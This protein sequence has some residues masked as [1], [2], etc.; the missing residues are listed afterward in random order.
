VSV[1]ESESTQ[2]HRDWPAAFSQIC[3]A[4]R[5][6]LV[7]WLT[8]IF[9]PH[10]AEDIA[11]EALARLYLRPGLID[12]RSDAWP[13]LSVVARNV[14]RDLARHNAFTTTVDAS[15][16]SELPG[17]TR[18]WDQVSARDDA[19]RL[20]AALRCLNPQDRA[21]IRRRDIQDQPIAEIAADVGASDNTVRQQLFRARR[22]LANAYLALGGDRTL[23]MAALVRLRCREFVRKYV[24]APVADAIGAASGLLIS[25]IPAAAVAAGAT[26]IITTYATQQPPHDAARRV[27]TVVRDERDPGHGLLRGAGAATTQPSGGRPPHA[28]KPVVDEHHSTGPVHVDVTVYR[29]PLAPG[30]DPTDEGGIWVEDPVTGGE[31]GVWWH[32]YG[33]DKGPVC[34]QSPPVICD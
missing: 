14:G 26:A 27:A 15:H 30:A 22:K 8:A 20:A 19:E 9:G 1:I 17:E 11:Q 33:H 4:H 12:D 21:L 5:G 31:T 7:R 23:G 10:D 2:P 6:R 18:V 13:W 32:G 16:L 24:P 25:A 28:R 3:D 29:N 34:E